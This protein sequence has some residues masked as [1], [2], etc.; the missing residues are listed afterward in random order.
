[1]IKIASLLRLH[2]GYRVPESLPASIGDGFL[3]ARNVFYSSV[4]I[5]SRNAGLNFSRRNTQSWIR[6]QALPFFSLQEIFDEQTVPYSDN[7]SIFRT[8]VEKNKDV[9]LPLPFIV[10]TLKKNYLLHESS[11][12]C[13]FRVIE[14]LRSAPAAPETE[15]EWFISYCLLSESFARVVERFAMFGAD[16][17]FHIFLLRLNSYCLYSPEN[18]VAFET[19]AAKFDLKKLFLLAMV[20]SLYSNISAEP[21]PKTTGRQ[22]ISMTFGRDLANS[23]EA[24]DLDKFVGLFVAISPAFREFT[25][26]AYFRLYDCETVFDRALSSMIDNASRMQWVFSCFKLLQQ[27]LFG[28]VDSRNSEIVA[29]ASLALSASS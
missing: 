2:D 24:E 28:E 3:C 27:R 12:Y 26:R 22:F 7:V 18:K 11:H 1:M 19:A 9:A 16:S 29:N 4:R 14:T 8:L 23:R 13:A 5:L 17:D 21:L 15:G 20:L 25:T 6:Y 10:D